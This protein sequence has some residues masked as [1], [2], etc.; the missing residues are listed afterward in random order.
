MSHTK[1]S[2]IP[3]L[4]V[5]HA[6]GEGWRVAARWP[7]GH[8]EDIADFKSELEANGW[9]AKDFQTWLETRKTAIKPNYRRPVSASERR[10]NPAFSE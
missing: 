7:D 10:V 6:E 5:R 1:N 3:T 8:V 4:Q 9:I 2:V